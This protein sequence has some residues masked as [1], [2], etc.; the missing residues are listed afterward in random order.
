MIKI[1]L[2]GLAVQPIALNEIFLEIK[3]GFILLDSLSI[4]CVPS[5]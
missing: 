3:L 5:L 1:Y 2:S 4:I